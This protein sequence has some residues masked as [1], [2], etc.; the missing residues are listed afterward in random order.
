MNNMM[1]P[2]TALSLLFFILANSILLLLVNGIPPIEFNLP[3]ESVPDNLIALLLE[4][5]SCLQAIDEW[6]KVP[7]VEDLYIALRY[8]HPSHSYSITNCIVNTQQRRTKF[9][10]TLTDGGGR[11]IKLTSTFT[12]VSSILYRCSLI[13]GAQSTHL[14]VF[15]WSK[16]GSHW[17]A[18]RP[19]FLSGPTSQGVSGQEVFRVVAGTPLEG[20]LLYF[21]HYVGYD[22]DCS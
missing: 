14:G 7:H 2:Y 6:V 21:N 4:A 10:F 12:K 20:I 5:A 22:L 17:Y 15:D 16:Q 13:K 3:I 18:L 9:L 1:F 19:Y 11:S 8:Y